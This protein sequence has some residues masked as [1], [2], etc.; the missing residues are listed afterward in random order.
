MAQRDYSNRQDGGFGE[1]PGSGQHGGQSYRSPTTD[2]QRSQSGRNYGDFRGDQ[3]DQYSERGRQ[4]GDYDTGG[5]RGFGGQQRGF[6]SPSG[7]GAQGGR[8]S[9][10]DFPTSQD[11]RG[12][13][14]DASGYGRYS[15]RGLQ[16]GSTASDWRRRQDLGLTDDRYRDVSGGHDAW[17]WNQSTERDFQYGQHQGRPQH[18]QFDPDYH[19]WRADQLRSLDNDYRQWRDERYKKFSEEFDSWRKNRTT[20]STSQGTTSAGST[21][22]TDLPGGTTGVTEGLGTGKTK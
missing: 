18:E 7:Y 17:A 1:G 4:A 16:G 21:L 10:N 14:G 2:G 12:S 20:R 22:G 13:E 6:D 9:S 15:Q 5:H 3:H 19:Q 11:F 8:Y